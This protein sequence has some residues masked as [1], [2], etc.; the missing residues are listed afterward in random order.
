M[1]TLVIIIG[2]LLMIA[3]LLG[4]FLPVI[5]GLPFSY[6]GLL[7]LQ[8][9]SS[10]PFSLQF[11]IIWGLIVVV[12]MVLDNVIPAYGT[13]KFGGSPYGVW[14]SILGLGIGF[15]FPPTG[16][17]LGPLI[18]AFLGELLSGKKSDQAFR[19]ALGSFM[20]FLVSTILKVIASG[21][22]AYYFFINI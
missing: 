8:F 17:V 14:G 16:L 12:L 10:H 6:A 19:S 5:P 4:S 9:T 1:E 20:G 22:M 18:G 21:M 11:F 7:I 15:F 13:K 3:G 2:A